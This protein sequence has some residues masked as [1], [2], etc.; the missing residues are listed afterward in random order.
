MAV[1]PSESYWSA[2]RGP[3]SVGSLVKDAPA[4]ADTFA[5]VAELLD[6][7][8][9]VTIQTRRTS[10]N[11][12]LANTSSAFADI[13][14]GGTA[15]SRPLDVVIP[16]LRVGDHFEF[17]FASAFIGTNNNFFLANAAIIKAGAVVRPLV[18]SPYGYSPLQKAQN[19]QGDLPPVWFPRNTVQEGDLEADGTLRIRPRYSLSSLNRELHASA[20]LPLIFEGRGPLGKAR[21]GLIFDGQSFTYAPADSLS[22]PQRV[23]ALIQAPHMMAATGISGTTYAQRA[24]TVAARTDYHV[25]NA[26]TSVLTVISGQSDLLGGMSADSLLATAEADASAR[27]AAG[28]DAVVGVTIPSMIEAWEWT[29]DMEAERIAYNDLLME[30]DVFDVVADIASIPELAD[31]ADT[32]YFSDGLHPTAAGADLMAPV[33]VEAINSVLN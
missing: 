23:S 19:V 10:G 15:A 21:L 24:A 32:T 17:R 11:I 3:S 8:S 27:L 33:V 28:F 13:D 6:R 25:R 22:L 7:A 14:P 2:P 26:H 12:T 5:E 20:D 1:H 16:G 18:V 4:D 29:P 30:S 9:P 31:P